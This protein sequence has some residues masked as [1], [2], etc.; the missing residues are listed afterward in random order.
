M[1]ANQSLEGL[2]KRA[3]QQG[4]ILACYISKNIQRFIALYSAIG[5]RRP[6]HKC[7][8]GQHIQNTLSLC[9]VG[10]ESHHQVVLQLH[11]FVTCACRKP[12][13]PHPPKLHAPSDV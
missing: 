3:N 12:L 10:L 13:L 7:K 4:T 1:Q 5:Q 6:L 8:P 9:I 2:L 11:D